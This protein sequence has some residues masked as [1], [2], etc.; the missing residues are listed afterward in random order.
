M[1]AVLVLCA[2][3]GSL[4][5]GVGLPFQSGRATD[6][7][8][9]GPPKQPRAA[10]VGRRAVSEALVRLGTEMMCNLKRADRYI[11]SPVSNL[12]LGDLERHGWKY[13]NPPEDKIFYFESEFGE[14]E[15]LT[16]TIKSLEQLPEIA[17]DF[18]TWKYLEV[19][20]SLPSNNGQRDVPVSLA[21]G[22]VPPGPKH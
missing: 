20:N 13:G 5:S 4:G 18:N 15:D 22:N 21:R 9:Y 3:W 10:A 11:P 1:A 19:S 2:R 7:S 12:H 14:E 17:K 8:L 16:N 6:G